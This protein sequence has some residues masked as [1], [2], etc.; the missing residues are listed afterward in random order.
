DAANFIF[1]PAQQ[2]TS[3]IFVHES[4]MARSARQITRGCLIVACAIDCLGGLFA[5]RVSLSVRR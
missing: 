5:Q 3:L 2:V 1:C 4:I